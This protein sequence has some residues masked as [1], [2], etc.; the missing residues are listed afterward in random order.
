MHEREMVKVNVPSCPSENLSVPLPVVA[1]L[2][3]VL[4]DLDQLPDLAIGPLGRR[5]LS[6]DESL[7]DSREVMSRWWTVGS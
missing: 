3:L 7:V 6:T 2:A 4:D 1:L 5:E